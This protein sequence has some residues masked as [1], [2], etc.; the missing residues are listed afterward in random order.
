[1]SVRLFG[2]LW[3]SEAL[4]Q[5]EIWLYFSHFFEIRTKFSLQNNKQ[6]QAKIWTADISLSLS[7]LWKWCTGSENCRFL[8]VS[9]LHLVGP[10]RFCLSSVPHVS[11]SGGCSTRM[12]RCSPYDCRIVMS[13]R[14]ASQTEVEGSDLPHTIRQ[15]HG[16][17]SPT[18]S[19]CSWS[20]QDLQF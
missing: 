15:V 11:G 20:W 17:N 6:S 12:S 4:L 8:S 2:D 13:P 14:S 1:M 16:R 10:Q 9:V 3:I 19:L 7:G 18:A 5:C